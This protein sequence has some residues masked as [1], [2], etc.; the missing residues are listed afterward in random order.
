MQCSVAGALSRHC[1]CN[2]KTM[3]RGC[4][5]MLSLENLTIRKH[6][7]NVIKFG[8]RC[9]AHGG[10]STSMFAVNCCMMQR[11]DRSA[12]EVVVGL[13]G[14]TLQCTLYTDKFRCTRLLFSVTSRVHTCP[15]MLA[16][17][18]RKLMTPIGLSIG[19]F[20]TPSDC[21]WI[22]MDPLAMA[23]C[24]HRLHRR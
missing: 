13:S 11:F 21:F 9:Q 22:H 15:G 23:A 8:R 4:I 16:G 20:T 5:R 14:L 24:I 7:F 1:L 3:R 2:S 17:E 18:E 19:S 6:L 10:P 12:M